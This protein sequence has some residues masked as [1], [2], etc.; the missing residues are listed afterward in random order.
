M[1]VRQLKHVVGSD[2]VGDIAVSGN[3][4]RS[5]E[6]TVDLLCSPMDDLSRADS[7][8]QTTRSIRHEV[9]GN[10]YDHTR[11]FHALA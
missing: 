5:E 11:R 7:H 10:L 4:I 2:L 8:E 1:S 6:H 9:V 3:A